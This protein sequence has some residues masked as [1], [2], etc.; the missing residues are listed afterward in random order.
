VPDSVITFGP[1]C[2]AVREALS[3]S[4]ISLTVREMDPWDSH[5]AVIVMGF[6]HLS[7]ASKGPPPPSWWRWFYYYPDSDHHGS[8]GSC[9]SSSLKSPSRDCPCAK[10]L[11]PVL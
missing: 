2:D 1:Y 3:T 10:Y 11:F 6:V 8:S 4:P 9:S 7:L 5:E